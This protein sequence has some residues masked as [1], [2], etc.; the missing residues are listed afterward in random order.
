MTEAGGRAARIEA[1]RRDWLR[2]PLCRRYALGIFD[3]AVVRVREAKGL[4]DCSVPWAFGWLADGQCEPLGAWIEPQTASEGTLRMLGDLKGRGVERIAYV[5]GIACLREP[6]STAFYGATIRSATDTRLAEATA[7]SARLGLP[8][9]E[10][11]S[12][13]VRGGLARA[14]RRHGSFETPAAALD[15]VAGAL[16]RTERRLDRGGE[17]AMLR[18]RRPGAQTASPS[19]EDAMARASWG[20]G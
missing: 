20:Q 14:T 1:F 17:I 18:A 12:E 16:Q 3:I 4:R 7:A 10:C 19:S 15:F 2:R 5:A 6:V 9:P 8:S 13:E 11:V